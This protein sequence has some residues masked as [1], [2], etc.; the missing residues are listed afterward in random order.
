MLELDDKLWGLLGL[1][2][3]WCCLSVLSSPISSLYSGCKAVFF[4]QLKV[5][6]KPKPGCAR[7]VWVAGCPLG[8]HILR[9]SN[10]QF[11]AV[12]HI[13]SSSGMTSLLLE[14]TA[15]AT[16]GCGRKQCPSSILGLN[17]SLPARA[18]CRGSSQ[19]RAMFLCLS[20]SPDP[21]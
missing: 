16:P 8:Q 5:Y 17:S 20:V 14:A 7:S 1:N 11:L 12:V 18:V 3:L 10:Y 15:P 6:L 4:T 19:P 2:F 21:F 9:D 13:W